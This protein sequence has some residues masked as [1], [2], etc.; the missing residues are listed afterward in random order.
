[1]T[2]FLILPLVVLLLTVLHGPSQA[3]AWFFEFLP[4]SLGTNEPI[5][6]LLTGVALL[7]LARIG[8]ASARS[9]DAGRTPVARALRRPRHPAVPP[10]STKRAA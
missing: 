9:A 2:K 8:I 3:Q 6:L 4:F 1:M 7:T 10:Q 5:T